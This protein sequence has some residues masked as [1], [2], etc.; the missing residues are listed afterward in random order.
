M[1]AQ[2]QHTALDE[3][4]DDPFIPMLYEAETSYEELTCL[5]QN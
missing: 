1:N 4:Y 3:L 5:Y 2:L